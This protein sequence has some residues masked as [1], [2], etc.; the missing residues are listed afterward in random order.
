MDL[1]AAVTQKADEV[2]RLGLAQTRAAIRAAIAGRDKRCPPL[3]DVRELTVDGAAG[4][5]AGRLY[6]PLDAADGGPALVFIH[7]GGFVIG[8]L[9]TND[10]FCRRLAAGAKV[11]VIAVTYRLAPEAKF[12][13]QLDDA[14]A[15]VRWVID[16]AASLGVRPDGLALSG[17]S[18]GAY[19]AIAVT[20]SLNTERPG[21]VGSQILVYPLMHIDDAIWSTTVFQDSRIVG[22]AAVAYIR[23]QLH[24]GDLF[25]PSLLD[26][27]MPR[28]PPTLIV[29]GG[30]LDPVRPDAK[31]YGEKI[32][33]MGTRLVTRE[34][35]LLPHGWANMTHASSIARK[36]VTETAELAGALIRGEDAP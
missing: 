19:L 8:D 4:P 22:R 27:D 32:A 31:R 17:D 7:G 18:A 35:P 14:M 36:A 24:E 28:P 9:D 33:A 5:L 3:A 23:S 6:R 1:K 10:A 2:H 29:T 12:P 30:Q 20:A 11:T 21:T 34:F 16:H 13:A 26:Q 25:A 15:A